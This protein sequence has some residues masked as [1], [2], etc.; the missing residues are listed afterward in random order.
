MYARNVI[1]KLVI[2]V[3]GFTALFWLV[4]LS[5]ILP[6]SALSTDLK[7]IPIL[8]GAGNFLFSIISG[9]VI[10]AQ[11]SK[12]DTL[13]G[14][15]RGE[16][17]TLRQLFIVAHHFPVK[18]RNEI[19]FHIYRYLDTYCKVSSRA[20]GKDLLYRSK[21]VDD[22]MV[23]IEDTMFVASKRHP[24]IGN[25][26]FTYLTRA[27]EYREIKL[28]SSVHQLP[29]P[30]RIFLFFA[31]GSVIIGSLFI[32]F[33]NLLYNYY[34]TLVVASLAFGIIMIVE[35]FDNPFRPGI[36]FLSVDAHK[37][38]RNE[39]RNKLEYYAFDFNKAENKELT[40]EHEA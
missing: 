26:A 21:S 17:S 6:Q 8:F 40:D 32:P 18:E 11:W 4:R 27:M 34:F 23:R 2:F 22:A 1:I 20:K 12:W 10:Q 31:T 9:F 15:T 33:T 16:V 29:L 19:R 28:Q 25:Q 13:M 39:I 38:L 5:G 35:D 24:D 30:I 37:N 3:T 14:A 7:S 36:Y